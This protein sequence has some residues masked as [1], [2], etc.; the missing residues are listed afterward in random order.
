MSEDHEK[1]QRMLEQAT[2]AEGAREDDLDP[3]AASLR[4]AWLSLGHLL[5]AA[6]PASYDVPLPFAEDGPKCSPLRAPTEGWSGEGQEKCS[7]L[8]SG[9]G[10]GVRARRWF[11]PAAG[12]LA[13]SLLIGVMTAWMLRDANRQEGSTPVPEQIAS[14]S[15]QAT[16]LAHEQPQTALAVNGP[17]WDD[18]FDEQL[19]QVGQQMAYAGNDQFSGTDAFGLVQYRME[20]FRQEVQADSL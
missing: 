10:Q 15:R 12:L 19:A 11:L 18:S 13:A 4:E 14:T 17:Q 16:S 5:E 6:Q 8:P 7:P 1:L 3:Q 9:E 2:A 20:Q